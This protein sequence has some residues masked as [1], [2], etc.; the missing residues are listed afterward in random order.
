MASSDFVSPSDN[1][2]NFRL[3]LIAAPV[4]LRYMMMQQRFN[5]SSSCYVTQRLMRL[6]SNKLFVQVDA[7]PE[8]ASGETSANASDCR[9]RTKRSW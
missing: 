9:E 2:R 1:D 3:E 7:D 6:L 8:S 4:E 5:H